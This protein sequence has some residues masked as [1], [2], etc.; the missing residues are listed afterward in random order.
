MH[1]IPEGWCSQQPVQDGCRH[2]G[3]DAEC[4][5]KSDQLFL[6]TK[7]CK[8]VLTYIYAPIKWTYICTHMSVHTQYLKYLQIIHSYAFNIYLLV[9]TVILNIINVHT[10]TKTHY[11]N[12]PSLFGNNF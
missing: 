12:K 2:F 11:I 3:S 1:L 5:G 6:D 4:N 7:V 8:C 10:S 9:R